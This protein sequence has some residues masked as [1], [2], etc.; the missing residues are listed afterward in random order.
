MLCTFIATDVTCT[1]VFLFK[2][3]DSTVSYSHSWKQP[4]MG[5]YWNIFMC[6]WLSPSACIGT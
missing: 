5:P 2:C 1:L 6:S 4:W 3:R